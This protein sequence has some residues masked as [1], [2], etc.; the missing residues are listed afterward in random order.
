MVLEEFLSYG[1]KF[2]SIILSASH[3]YYMRYSYLQIAL[4]LYG[5]HT[6]ELPAN[7][8]NRFCIN[9]AIH[10]YPT[11]TCSNVQLVQ[12]FI[13]KA[14]KQFHRSIR[15]TGPDYLYLW[16]FECVPQNIASRDKQKANVF[17]FINY[18]V[19]Y[20]TTPSHINTFL[21]QSLH[22]HFLSITR[23]V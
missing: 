1:L 10:N 13:S 2:E 6:N 18:I 12:M 16:I 7:H 15:H 5:F 3:T 22:P 20:T 11:W 4:F 21:L 14:T 8:L 19:V 9:S 23:D 17:F